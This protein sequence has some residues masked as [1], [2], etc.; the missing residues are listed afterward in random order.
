M[1]DNSKDDFKEKIEFE[2]AV[3]LRNFEIDLFWKRSWFFGALI[4]AETTAFYKLKTD[5]IFP[6][7]TMA[8]IV[9][10][11]AL[12][13]CLM[14]RGSKYWQE[15]WEYITM[16][17]EAS[18]GLDLTRLKKFEDSNLDTWLIKEYPGSDRNE[19]FF[20]DVAM[21]SKGDN[22]LT[23]ARRFSVSKITF[24]V[25]DIIF[26]ASVLCWLNESLNIFSIRPNWLFTVKL[27]IFYFSFVIYIFLFWKKGKVYEPFY[28]KMKDMKNKEEV[29]KMYVNNEI[30]SEMIIEREK[31]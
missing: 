4:L 31:K 19:W 13:Q 2:N 11:T 30:V 22:F 20:I 15:R 28:K 3:K 26:I 9:L 1:R 7:V 21:L 16:N 17:R 5:E 14:N 6:P 8:F 29:C 24:L 10:L 18:L 25:W 23:G 12:A 27:S